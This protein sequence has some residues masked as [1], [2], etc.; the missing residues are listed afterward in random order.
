MVAEE[1]GA[2]S[3]LLSSVCAAMASAMS[4]AAAREQRMSMP[5][6]VILTARS[7]VI[8]LRCNCASISFER[9]TGKKPGVSPKIWIA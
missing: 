6:I 3:K 8:R 2:A 4:R 5:L 9:E 1:L 7:L